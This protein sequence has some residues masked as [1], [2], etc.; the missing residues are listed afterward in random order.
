LLLPLLTPLPPPL[1]LAAPDVVDG[2]DRWC[3][4]DA[5]LFPRA[6]L[7]DDGAPARPPP[8]PLPLLVPLAAL[9]FGVAKTAV[10]VAL[11]AAAGPFSPPLLLLT[12]VMMLLLTLLDLRLLLL[13]LLLL[14]LLLAAAAAARA[15][16]GAGAVADGTG[17]GGAELDRFVRVAEPALPRPYPGAP[18]AASGAASIFVA[19]IGDRLLLRVPWPDDAA[20]SGARKSLCERNSRLRAWSMTN[21][22]FTPDVT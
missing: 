2:V 11:V 4:A 16:A 8:L 15:G 22:L 1:L 20:T 17:A 5:G 12:A 10:A 19:C 9:L 13:A 18:A 7:L 21:L 3:P 14:L 6:G